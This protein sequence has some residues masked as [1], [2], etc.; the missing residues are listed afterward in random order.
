MN[1]VMRFYSTHE[2]NYSVQSPF[3]KLPISA[4]VAT[5]SSRT[6]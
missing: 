2:T 6:R 3:L 4:R 5:R 1:E